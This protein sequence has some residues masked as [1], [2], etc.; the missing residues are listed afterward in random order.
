M[1]PWTGDLRVTP[2]HSDRTLAAHTLNGSTPD[3]HTGVE[4]RQGA[5]IAAMTDTTPPNG[6][7]WIT[8]MALADVPEAPRNPKLHDLDG[9]TGSIV[10][11]D[12][13]DPVLLDERTG[14]LVG[15]H[16]RKAALAMLQASGA[17][18]PDGIGI[19]DDVFADLAD[20]VNA[21]PPT[22]PEGPMPTGGDDDTETLAERF[23]VP[24]FSVLDRRSGAWQERR[25]R[26]RDLGIASG[27]GRDEALT[28]GKSN[29]SD[30]VTAKLRE[31]TGGTSIF[32]P[33]IAELVVRWFSAP[34][35]KVLDPFA[36]GSV[37]GLVAGI[38]ARHYIGVDIRPEQVAANR[39]QADVAAADGVEPVWMVGD[40]TRLDETATTGP[41]DLVFSCPP[42]ADL[43]V[44]SDNPQDISTWPYD[45]FIDGHR[46]AIATACGRLNDDRFAAWV[47][48][49]VRAPNGLFRGLVAETIGAFTEAGMGFLGQFVIVDSVGTAALRAARPFE[50]NRK[51]T[52]TH[53]HLLVFVKGDSKRAAAWAGDATQ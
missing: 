51:P 37:R 20:L 31:M 12:F 48:G 44:Y 10:E 46:S 22:P 35:A 14:L 18:R 26:W 30:P 9:I 40:A 27:D 16:G 6:S 13:A 19:T 2:W 41:V 1:R 34:G 43:E 24:P 32:D 15:G 11:H 3:P 39:A 33:V 28:F 25:R 50:A 49:D 47:I 38:L 36:G 45:D 7:R 53:Q 42:Y 52:M 8:Y 4:P 29:G 21:T 5:T 23:I 17:D